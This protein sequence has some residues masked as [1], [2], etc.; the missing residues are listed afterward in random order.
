MKIQ[1]LRVLV[2]LVSIVFVGCAGEVQVENM[3]ITDEG[4]LK[5]SGDAP[6]ADNISVESVFIN[7]GKD[8]FGANSQIIH[9][10][11]VASLG[12][13]RLLAPNGKGLYKL[14]AHV[15]RSNPGFL[16]HSL[17]VQYTLIRKHDEKKIYTKLIS[18]YGEAEH[19]DNPADKYERS[20]RNNITMLVDELYTLKME[21]TVG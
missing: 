12:K 4:S 17:A 3:K 6:F 18:S 9:E 20:M 11:L 19:F 14:K 5:Y 21:E 15:V 13:A 7:E 1:H 10:T 2:M 8:R 16:G